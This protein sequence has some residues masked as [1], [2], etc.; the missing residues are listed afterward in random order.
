LQ[1]GSAWRVNL[2]DA[3]LRGLRQ[4]LDGTGVQVLY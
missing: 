1:G 2:S 4:R 3:L